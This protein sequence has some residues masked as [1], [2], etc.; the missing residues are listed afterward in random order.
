MAL[1]EHFSALDHAGVVPILG[2]PGLI[3]ERATVKECLLNPE[4]HAKVVRKTLD[5]FHP[6][7]ALP[8]LD[9]TVEAESYGMKPEY[10]DREPPQL[11]SFMPLKSWVDEKPDGSRI[12]LMVETARLISNQITGVPVGFYVTGPFTLAGQIVG[13]QN[14]FMG[15]IKDRDRVLNLVNSCTATIVD[16]TKQLKETGLD[17]LV[18]ADP[19][20]SLLSPKQFKD[21]AKCPIVNVVNAFSGDSILH[22]CGRSGHLLK[23]MAETGVS[24]VSIDENIKLTAAI[25]SLPNNM[26]ILGNYSPTKLAFEG[27][28]EIRTGVREMLSTVDRE[29]QVVASTGCDI[30][31]STPEVNIH[32]FIQ[33]VK[34]YEHAKPSNSD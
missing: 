28:D 1:S 17:F 3:S 21:F 14:L 22:M 34:T 18:I 6:D 15:L 13:I 8:L 25:D 24:G 27:P 31:A 11:R 12:P 2:Y 26:V 7:A 29:A 23:Q 20:P 5:Q 33:T 10:T 19:T 32:T 30:S 16:Y 4:L 9:L